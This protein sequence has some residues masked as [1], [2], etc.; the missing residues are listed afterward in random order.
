MRIKRLRPRDI[1]GDNTSLLLQL[2]EAK[3]TIAR[4]T[5]DNKKQEELLSAAVA[6]AEQATESLY[7][8]CSELVSC[9]RWKEYRE[10]AARADLWMRGMKHSCPVWT[11]KWDAQIEEEEEKAEAELSKLPSRLRDRVR[12]R[13]RGRRQ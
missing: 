6:K 13:E 9:K 7:F 8:A 5:E 11:A 10:I 1:S 12:I 2:K 4:L 3:D